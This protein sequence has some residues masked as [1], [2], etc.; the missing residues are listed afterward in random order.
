MSVAPMWSGQHGLA[1]V[2]H[3]FTVD[4][5]DLVRLGERMGLA[6]GRVKSA[7]TDEIHHIGRDVYMRAYR[8]LSG[9]AHKEHLSERS[10]AAARLTIGPE[11]ASKYGSLGAM[12]NVRT[13]R[14]RGALMQKD[15]PL[16][17]L[18]QNDVFYGALWERGIPN[19]KAWGRWPSPQEP[20]PWMG[21]A[22]AEVDVAGRGPSRIRA[23]VERACM[24]ALR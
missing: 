19:F 9:D 5:R 14:L 18:I 6:A 20:R 12:L 8:N 17:S 1:P 4:V 10:Y 11:R 23:A 24:E 15:G 7:V 22:V 16:S 13:N 21:Q 3:G 2:E